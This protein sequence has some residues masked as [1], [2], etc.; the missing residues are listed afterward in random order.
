MTPIKIW[1]FYLFLQ[2]QSSIPITYRFY[3]NIIYKRS[4]ILLLIFYTHR[5]GSVL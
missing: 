3:V 5:Y 2:P 1:M 4:K